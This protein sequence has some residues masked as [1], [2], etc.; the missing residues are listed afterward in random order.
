MSVPRNTTP[1]G[2]SPT[3]RQV[4]SEPQYRQFES[5]L[6]QH[7]GII[8][9]D[10]R[11]YLVESRL[12]SLLRR[13]QLTGFSELLSKLPYDK[14]L[15]S[16]VISAMTTNETSWFRDQ[17]PYAVLAQH[18]LPECLHSSLSRLRIWSAACSSGQEP[19]SISIT[20]SEFLA[21]NSMLTN[22]PM[23]IVATD[24]SAA[25][26]DQAVQ[27]EFDGIAMTRGMSDRFLNKYFKK[28]GEKWIIDETV[29]KRVSFRPF[30]LLDDYTQLGKFN[31]IFCRNVLIYFSA[32]MK[33]QIFS[34]LADVLLP[35]GY[36]FLG[37]S[38]S[39]INYSDAFDMVKTPAGVVY[40]LKP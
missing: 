36:L 24:I 25:V 19:Y 5:F 34:R 38:E 13:Y 9:G 17:Y 27:G 26:L 22:L 14:D 15:K 7:T 30:N 21:V 29:R 4:I 8:L 12:R 11:H 18:I 20:I 28:Q 32:D 33:K 2:P 6:Q 37:G 10:D 31:V 16:D 40:R 3:P 1:S 35:G 39:M 23:E